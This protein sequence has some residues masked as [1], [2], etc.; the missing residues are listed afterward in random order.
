MDVWLQNQ[1]IRLSPRQAI[2]KGG[3]ADVFKISGK[4]LQGQNLKGSWALKLFKQ[5]EHPDY[6]HSPQEQ[7]AARQRLELKQRKL[8]QFPPLLPTRV[9]APEHVVTDP[10][11]QQILGYI[12]PLLT[13]AESLLRY[14]DRHFRQ[15][16]AQQTIV[17]IFQDLHDT[18]SK[19]HF[20]R[21][22]I[23]DFND[24]NV[25]VKGK[26]A[27]LIDADS[28]QFGRF[29][30][31][32]FTARFVDPL[33][34][35]PQ[36][37]Q[38][39]L[40]SPHTVAS[41]W[42]ALTVMLFQTLLFVDP[43]G[44]LYKPKDPS[45]KV[46]QAARPL[47]RITVFN[48]EVRYPKPALPYRYLPDELLHH[49]QQVFE[50]DWRGELPRSLLDNLRWT[51]CKTCGLE[52][53]RSTCPQCQQTPPAAVKATIRVKGTVKATTVFSTEGTILQAWYQ[54]DHSTQQ[55]AAKQSGVLHWLSWHQ[56]EFKRGQQSINPIQRYQAPTSTVILQ[57]PL[58]SYT[59]WRL[60][61]QAT[62]IGQAN[63]GLVLPFGM[64]L[65]TQFSTRSTTQAA[66]PAW[67]TEQSSTPERFSVE[68]Y[69][70]IPQFEVN[71]QQCFWIQQGQLYRTGEL[72]PVFVGDVLG[73]GQTQFW[74]GETFGFGFYRAG[75]LNVGFVFDTQR[76]GLNDRVALPSWS[77][78]LIQSHCSL[79]R[80]RA[81][82]FLTTQ[83][84]GHLVYTCIVIGRT[85]EVLAIAKAKPT[86]EHWLAKLAPQQ[87]AWDTSPYL[88]LRDFLLAA[89]DD[90]I[91][92]IEL[93]GQQLHLAKIFTDTEAFVATGDRLLPG[94]QG[95]YV[96][97]R[98]QIRLLQL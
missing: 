13:G 2:G 72:G 31:P 84:Q 81:W 55:Q 33:L 60:Q 25:L 95:I 97:S 39:M 74:L 28:F 89:S 58:H 70:Q 40:Q 35:D 11:G 23:G 56:G 61:A 52:H 50:Q 69:R 62:L 48:P 66:T 83:E 5:P 92:R 80:D 12:M 86:D 87:Q 29:P 51:R 53:A 98:T 9:I 46:P 15:T 32:M 59:R 82:L 7:Q 54:P 71:S 63:Q 20:A 10:T 76:S 27:Y 47:K 16:I 45:Q 22:V 90:G 68:S 1:R 64:P 30:S 88:A 57:G 78:E 94:P 96:V 37:S 4:H 6:A 42:Y 19:L 17:E 24:L 85:G 26:E 91:L 79:S 75:Q 93:Q 67:A 43:Y 18:V 65:S 41:D 8:Q 38:P 44:G 34:C 21:V 14:G 77:G 73:A 3:E 36:A 49:F